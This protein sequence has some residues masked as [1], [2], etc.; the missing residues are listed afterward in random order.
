MRYHLLDP[1]WRVR[2]CTNLDCRITTE[3]IKIIVSYYL[4]SVYGECSVSIINIVNIVK[5]VN[6]VNIVTIVNIF[7]IDSIVDRANTVNSVD[8]VNI[9]NIVNM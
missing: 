5:I 6:I 9:A 4:N 7:N 3:S 8:I 2:N 1:C